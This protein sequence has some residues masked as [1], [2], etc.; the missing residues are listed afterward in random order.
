MPELAFVFIGPL[1]TDVSVLSHIRNIY[2][3]GSKEH[4]QLPCL[5]KYFSVCLIPYIISE[6]TRNVYPTKLN[7]YLALGRPVVSTALPEIIAFNK[8][9]GNV[10]EIASGP[11]EFSSAILNAIGQD[12]EA[13]RKRRIEAAKENSWQSRIEKMSSLIGE[14]I[15]R[16]IEDRESMWKEKFRVS[17]NRA[18]RKFMRLALIFGSAYLLIFYTPFVWWLASPLKI[19]QAP[20]SAQAIV[21]F[22][23]G[24]GESG[25]PA[26]GYEERVQY[27]VDLYKQGYAPKII[28]SSGYMFVF[29]EP[30][31]MKALA[32]SLGVPASDI[33]LEDQAKN[34]YQNVLYTARIL[35]SDGRKEILLVSSP[36]HMR[37]AALIFK[38]LAPDMAV[39]YTPLPKSSFYAHPSRDLKGRRIYRQVSLRQLRAIVHE[40]LGIIY[41][42]W[43]GYA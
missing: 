3:L 27:A 17:Y 24:V 18:R 23:G 25:R 21:V 11:E 8:G 26:Q 33:I 42:I 12:N 37:R 40:Y 7:E 39:A 38:K 36:Y 13:F 30:L 29:K 20:R 1:Q 31:V 22:A 41:Y 32:V 6:Y 43:K 9:Y 34:T 35:R 4:R 5:I 16:R 28:F 2:F 15:A 10:V 14:A 19:E